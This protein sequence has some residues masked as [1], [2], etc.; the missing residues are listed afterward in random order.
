[1]FIWVWNPVVFRIYIDCGFDIHA[2]HHTCVRDHL[3]VC[4]CVCVS[5]RDEID[6][7][8]SHVALWG[9]LCSCGID[10]PNCLPAF[11]LRHTH[12]HTRT[13]MHAHTG[14]PSKEKMA[15]GGEGSD[16]AHL[17]SPSYMRASSVSGSVSFH[18]RLLWGKCST[19]VAHVSVC[20]CARVVPFC[21]SGDGCCCV[22]VCVYACAC[23]WPCLCLCLCLGV[24]LC[25]CLRLCL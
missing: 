1:M 6:K 7:Y 8:T 10:N 13:Y 17:Q 21:G 23:V 18:G 4:V 12:A 5:V 15:W 14:E 19:H 9:G 3:F 11:S 22:C 20:I 24:C 16:I 25:L 2:F